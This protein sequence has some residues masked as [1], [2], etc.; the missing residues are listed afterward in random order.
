LEPL[1]ATVEAG[2]S[3]GVALRIRNTGDIVEEYHV[4]VVGEPAL[5]CAI[6]QSSVRLYPGTTA[7]IQLTFSP[8][9]SPDSAA[10]PHPFGVRVTPVENYEAVQVP[11]G[12]V[13]ITPFVDV[14]AELLPI[15]VRGWRRGKPRL[16]VDNYG[17]T[18][19]TAAVNASTSGSQVDFDVRKPS[20]QVPPGRAHFSVLRLRPLRLLWLG[21]KV[22]HPYT[23]TLQL[24][25]SEPVSTSGTYLQS[26]LLPRWMS[27]LF[28]LL[29]V[30]IA[31]FVGLW[32]S[33]HPSVASSATAQPSSAP[34][35][36]AT[37]P[38]TAPPTTPPTTPPASSPPSSPPASKAA[39]G[40]HPLPSPV[41]WWKFANGSGNTA[42]NSVNTSMYRASFT[43]VSWC[44]NG[45]DCAVFSGNSTAETSGAVL[46]TG[47]G[48]DFTVA[49]WVYLASTGS[50]LETMVSQDGSTASG[51]Y[52]QYLGSASG[53]HWAFSRP[54]AQAVAN[55]LAKARTWTYVAG[56]F[57][58]STGT[59]TVYV[60]GQ[61]EGTANDSAP[62][63][64]DGP[65]VMGRARAKS[66][67]AD[68]FTGE[69]S[70][71]QIYDSALS[72]AD[73]Q[74]TQPPIP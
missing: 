41:A 33:I 69:L 1:S 53:G 21:Q 38:T 8:P 31:V 22:S 65:V 6:D 16:V 42:I 23:T 46:D 7:T 40:G 52:L 3:A 74:R 4:D 5:W 55:D 63:A 9:R 66:E 59:L 35:D 34:T 48:H 54:T 27:R 24:S 26:A 17:N 70:Q 58:A 57:D 28:A 30:L 50:A 43:N 56:T 11:E 73:I 12:N 60:N 47:A 61:E 32:L 44:P 13:T 25:G 62:S 36:V 72:Q 64:S 10:G 18:T 15:T 71:V 2:G 68:W 51:F 45:G 29:L 37:M 49:A 20:I 39:G 19:A 67:N 14:R